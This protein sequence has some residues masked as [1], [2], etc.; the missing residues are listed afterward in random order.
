MKTEDLSLKKY[1][2]K[3][4]K[5]DRLKSVKKWLIGTYHRL[6]LG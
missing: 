4:I 6:N 3:N 1:I 2:K 5:K